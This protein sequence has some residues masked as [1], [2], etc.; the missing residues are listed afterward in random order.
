M[1]TITCKAYS[2]KTELPN[3]P[4]ESVTPSSDWPGSG[5]T[6]SNTGSVGV[7]IKPIRVY[8]SYGVFTH[9][10]IM[11]GSGTHT[12]KIL[13]VPAGESCH[14]RAYFKIPVPDPCQEK[15]ERYQNLDC[16]APD[17]VSVEACE[18]L[19]RG[20]LLSLNSCETENGEPLTT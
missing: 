4:I 6:V 17:V 9:W 8:P 3:T 13:T 5:D 20:Y 15:R 1:A 18:E 12:K 7:E 10:E 19:R 11:K 14:A 2:G 16:S